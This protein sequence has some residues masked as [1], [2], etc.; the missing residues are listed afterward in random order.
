MSTAESPGAPAHIARGTAAF[1]H[2][3]MAVF[4]AGWSTFAL[5]YGIQPLMPVFAAEFSVSPA[6]S[7]LVISLTTGVMAVAMLVMGSLSES[8]GR[9]PMIGLSIAATSTLTLL[10]AF[11]GDFWQLL[12]L[13]ALMGVA[14]AGMPSTTMAY[15]GEE[16]EPRSIGLAMGLYIA[17]A[18]L[19]GMSGRVLI[20]ALTD[21]GS[22]R[23][24][25]GVLG[26]VGIGCA[27]LFWRALPPSRHFAPQ[28]MRPALQL[29]SLVGHLRDPALPWLFVC[30]FLL[31]GSF[32][33]L[34]N[35][36]GFRL[37]APPYNLSQTAVG[38]LFSVYLLGMVGSTL[39]GHLAERLG[40]RKM[41]WFSILMILI[42]AEITRA[43]PLWLIVLG[44]A[45]L[46]IGFFA[47]HSIA[48]TWVTRRARI[49]K[50]Q[51]AS[52][53]LFFYYVGSS[54]V[55]TLGGLVWAGHGWSGLV[56]LVTGLQIAGLLVALRLWLLP[57]LSTAPA[58]QN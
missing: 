8:I 17:G 55:G 7:S 30:G 50:A 37:L 18:G 12:A 26:A 43:A 58:A 20:S 27:L 23:M 36:A 40:R 51:A 29:R 54:V 24:A 32:V 41:M 34:Y 16:I 35:Y 44:I 42:G 5:I 38:A 52:L 22:W 11:T 39:A 1:R 47:A 25:L 21:L 2:T 14:F 33:T 4:V 45:V 31:M 3:N 28:Q 57:P 13:R 48:S 56:W 49:A 9:K 19:G 6:T 46:T 53:Y 15:L 10:C